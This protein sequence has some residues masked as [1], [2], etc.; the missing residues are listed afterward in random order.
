MDDREANA[1]RALRGEVS[2]AR[3]WPE[4]VAEEAVDERRR[5]AR[6]NGYAASDGG[7][8]ALLGLSAHELHRTCGRVVVRRRDRHWQ[9]ADY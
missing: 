4:R 5:R 6:G 8:G 2:L 7:T 3:T 1:D 9:Q